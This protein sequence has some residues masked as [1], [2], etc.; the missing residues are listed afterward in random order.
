MLKVIGEA[1]VSFHERLTLTDRDM[2]GNVPEYSPCS[3]LHAKL[4]SDTASTLWLT[5]PRFLN[6]NAAVGVFGNSPS[7]ARHHVEPKLDTP[8]KLPRSFL[9][10]GGG[11]P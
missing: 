8:R 6:E 10:Q 3:C 2:L 11:N 1:L 4:V 9:S 7:H 5:E